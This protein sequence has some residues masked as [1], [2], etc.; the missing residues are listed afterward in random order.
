MRSLRGD[1]TETER[2]VVEERRYA[3][4]R[5]PWYISI[6]IT[7]VVIVALFLAAGKFNWLPSLPNPFGTTTVDRSQP[8]VLQSIENMSRYEAADGNFQLV[9]D[10]DKEAKF[11]PSALLGK[12]TL[13]VAAGTVGSY[14][15][16]GKAGVTVSS[17]RRSATIVLPHAALDKAALDPKN[18]Y[19][20]AESRGLF[21]RIGD[22]FSSDPNDQQQLNILAVQK[23]QTAAAASG[24][25]TRAE[26][27]TSAMLK[28]L[29]GSLGFTTV[30]VT[31]K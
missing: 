28:G 31:F 9:V 25:T 3:R 24:L 26:Q 12:R 17:D 18:S 21:N 20:Y 22:F 7:F 11:L 23:I 2:P 6:P 4:R 29:L 10:I 1:A 15:D 5:V 30:T 13:Y 8:A 27:N 14:V 16:M 19:T